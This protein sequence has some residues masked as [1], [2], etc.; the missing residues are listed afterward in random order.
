MAP[1]TLRHLLPRFILQPLAENAILHGA[2]NSTIIT[3]T[4]SSYYTTDE[5]IIEIL[6]N[7]KG[8]SVQDENEKKEK[9]SLGIGTSNVRERLRIYY[10]AD[11]ILQ[12]ISQEGKGTLC[13]ITIPKNTEKE[14]LNV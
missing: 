3:I 13:R 8:F 14:N 6:D 2:S 12:I 4:V 10:G 7:G 1:D 9:S 5:L 11:N